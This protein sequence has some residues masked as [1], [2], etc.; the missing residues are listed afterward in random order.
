MESAFAEHL[1]SERGRYA[2]LIRDE[3]RNSGETPWN[4][5]VFRKLS[6][7]PIPNILNRAMTNPDSF[8]FNG[9][10]W[11][12]EKGGYERRAFKD[13]MNDGGL[14]REIGGGWIA[15]LQ[16]HFSLH[17]SRRKIKHRCIY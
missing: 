13:Y 3:I 16:H 14:N 11:Y 9:A 4:A 12:S 17:G 1:L 7:V 2:I 5:Y 8:S 10:V 6:R 15:L